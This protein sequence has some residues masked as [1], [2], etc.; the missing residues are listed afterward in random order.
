[1]YVYTFVKSHMLYIGSHLMTVICTIF[2]DI[3][4][5]STTNVGDVLSVTAI[6][7]VYI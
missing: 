7:V 6:R 1:M 4:L 5:G 2:I 3:L